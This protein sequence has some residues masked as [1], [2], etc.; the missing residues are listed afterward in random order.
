VG[1]DLQ[2][3]S[4]NGTPVW[5]MVVTENTRPAR[6][7]NPDDPSFNFNANIIRRIYFS[8]RTN[9]SGANDLDFGQENKVY[10]P[11]SSIRINPVQ[12][13]RYAVVGS[14]VVNNRNDYITYFGRRRTANPLSA[15]ELALTRRFVMDPAAETV[16]RYVWNTVTSQLNEQ[17][18]TDVVCLPIGQTFTGT[19]NLGIS[20]P[21]N[22]YVGALPANLVVQPIAD[23]LKFF[24]TATSRDHYYDTP[25]DITAN[26][27]V[28]FD[29][30]DPNAERTVHLQRLANPLANYD[31]ISNPY[32]TIDSSPVNLMAFNGAEDSTNEGITPQGNLGL[33]SLERE[34]AGKNLFRNTFS[35]PAVTAGAPVVGD[36]H[37]LSFE[38]DCTFGRLNDKYLADANPN[39]FAWLTWNNRPYVSQYE[40]VNVPYQPSYFLTRSFSLDNGT[41]VYAPMPGAPNPLGLSPIRGHFDHLFNFY[42]DQFS[43]GTFTPNLYRVLD[44]TEVPSR[45]VGTERFLNPANYS[46]PF[47]TI[48]SYRYPGKLNLNTVMGNPGGPSLIWNSLMRNYQSQFLFPNWEN[49]RSSFPLRPSAPINTATNPSPRNSTLFR[50][51]GSGTPLLDFSSTDPFN[52][53]QRNAYFRYDA[54]QRLG[55]LVT[56]R[57]SV[58]A[59]WITV[60]Y[61]EIEDNGRPTN[62]NLGGV[63]LGSETGE[64]KRHRGFYIFDRS[65]PVAFEPGKNHN[66]ENA[67]LVRR[68]IQ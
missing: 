31:P 62:A 12:R 32:L 20:D 65:I 48:S 41:N 3:T 2:K 50:D 24:D 16:K 9:P 22:G 52:N 66:I 25:L 29:G 37:L 28:Q 14:Y 40:L 4:P 15:A 56:G 27:Q 53:S 7:A 45:F 55:N 36:Q 35:S 30:V 57:S 54:R 47:D 68:I 42:A 17:L 6:S 23:G 43:D 19:R 34:S 61:F 39:P 67:I 58:F 1:V 21:V 44:F 33:V 26:T 51:N 13:G 63:E 18:Y 60:G 38:F 11:D 64:V 5:R 49:S 46:P 8:P 59:I 10:F